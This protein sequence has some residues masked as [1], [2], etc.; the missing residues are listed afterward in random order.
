MMDEARIPAILGRTGD[1]GGCRCA[2]EENTRLAVRVEEA[3]E[4]NCP[5]GV[6]VGPPVTTFR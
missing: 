5:V 4:L 2:A 3:G 1:A 6:V